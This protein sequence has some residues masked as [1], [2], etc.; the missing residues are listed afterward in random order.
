MQYRRDSQAV[1]PP[2]IKNFRL[3]NW[4]FLIGQAFAD[5]LL[6]RDAKLAARGKWLQVV[7]NKDEAANVHKK[8]LR[9]ARNAD[10][11]WN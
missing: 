4:N 10:S 2:L 5:F 8:F 6:E 3:A 7:P 11:I 1:E 9:I